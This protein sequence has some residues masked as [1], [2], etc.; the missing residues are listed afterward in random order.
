MANILK[1]YSL[2]GGE[3]ANMT[4]PFR[5]LF[6]SYYWDIVSAYP[7]WF[8]PNEIGGGY[9][10][11]WSFTMPLYAVDV[12]IDIRKT[13]YTPWGS[14]VSTWTVHIES[15]VTCGTI[16]YD[17]CCASACN[18]AWLTRQ[19]GWQNYL[20]P[21][22]KEFR[23]D[24]GDSKTFKQSDYVQKY[25]EISDVFNGKICSTG[26]IPKSHVDLLDSLQ[27]SIQ[28][29]LWNDDTS[30]WDIPILIDKK[31]FVKYKTSDKFY[32]V[33]IRFIYATELPIQTQ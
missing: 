12:D 10:N 23:V 18:I 31:S 9:I 1:S 30:N 24:V 2:C 16:E 11:G 5:E 25:S 15:N 20:F 6:I 19:G 32:D 17:A 22:V 13:T 26:D 14:S 29:Y 28:A 4:L 33:K 8:I 7:D 21:G 27:Y 3:Y